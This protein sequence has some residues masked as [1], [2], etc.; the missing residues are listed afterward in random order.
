MFDS[1][2]WSPTLFAPAARY[3]PAWSGGVAVLAPGH[4]PTV[5][6]Y[7]TPRLQGI[8]PDSIFRVDSRRFDA[9]AN[10]WP[11]GTFVVVVRHASGDWLRFLE[12]ERH[13][14]CG[15]AYLMDD[16]IPGAWRCGDVPLDYG[17]WTT[18]RYLLARHGLAQVCDRIWVSTAA[19]QA[20]CAPTP[21]TVI[22]PL[23]WEP[24]RD[25]ALAGSRRWGYHGT[26]VHAREMRWLVPV[27]AEV[28]RQVPEAEFEIFGG[29][30]V[31]HW[32]RGIPRVRVLQPKPWP[33]YVT[34]CRDSD[35]AVGL[36]PMLPGRFNAVRSH[37]KVFDIARCGAVG[38][39]SARE[40]YAP[41]RAE[42]GTALLPDEQSAWVA[43]TVRLLQDDALR[44]AQYQRMAAW[45]HHRGSG[46]RFEDWV[47]PHGEK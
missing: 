37:T 14:W 42:A 29:R 28:Q 39:F 25:A 24:G 19:L 4:I 46:A 33:D 40:P 15:V 13:R 18:G 1:W 11:V 43:E 26:H 30:G 31:A 27:V 41:L 38:I 3:H 5:D 32:F 8:A 45:I 35:L 16:D 17:L 10:D 44:I 36:A 22:E 6:F 7:L 23:P 21:T 47:L 34:H 12:R 9:R 20:R 2:P